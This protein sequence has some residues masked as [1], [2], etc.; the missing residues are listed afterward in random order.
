[1]STTAA[2]SLTG[3]IDPKLLGP[4]HR[5]WTP[6]H[7]PT[8]LRLWRAVERGDVEAREAARMLTD[9]GPRVAIETLN[10]RGIRLFTAAYDR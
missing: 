3:V 9:A 5:G 4:L 1:M 8:L 7:R 2:E 10:K 6:R